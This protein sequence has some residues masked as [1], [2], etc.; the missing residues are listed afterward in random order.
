MARSKLSVGRFEGH[1][2]NLVK[3]AINFRGE[4]PDIVRGYQFRLLGLF[5]PCVAVE[6]EGGEIYFL[7]TSDMV[8]SRTTYERRS[9]DLDFM[10]RA[11]DTV[12]R[13]CGEVVANHTLIDVGANIGT[14]A[15]PGITRYGASSV[16]AFEPSPR[17]TRLLRVNIAA[18]DLLEK[19]D[20]RAVAVS[21]YVGTA[22]LE[23]S[24]T[25]SGDHRVRQSTLDGEFGEANRM[26][27][28]VPVTSLAEASLSVED[29]GLIWM[30]VQG[31]EG[32]VLSGAGILL[33][34]VPVVSEYWPYG[35]QRAGGL[36][37]FKDAVRSHYSRVVVIRSAS[38]VPS[39]S[40]FEA[41]DIDSLVAL[42]GTRGVSDLLLLP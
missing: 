10:D 13:Y 32:H 41:R 37:M 14:S 36:E 20:V 2:R 19:I 25:N 5:T 21:N 40:L 7:D 9:F 16:V 18:N 38:S 30:D 12:K 34:S 24:P 27:V 4:R 23:L 22:E 8:L 15:V 31:H 26:T 28:I 35:L 17:N 1:C 33:G 11:M 39:G 42:I 3:G 6:S 29:V